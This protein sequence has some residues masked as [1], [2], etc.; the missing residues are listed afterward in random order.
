M[1]SGRQV[2]EMFNITEKASRKFAE[3]LEKRRISS[4]TKLRVNFGGIG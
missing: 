1:L 3:G 2:R 4:D